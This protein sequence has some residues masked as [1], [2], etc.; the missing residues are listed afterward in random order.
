MNLAH[1]LLLVAATLPGPAQ[2][3]GQWVDGHFLC[4]RDAER[5]RL[6]D[7][8]GRVRL[9][10]PR[11]SAGPGP[12]GQLRLAW[13][14]HAWRGRFYCTVATRRAGSE[15]RR[16][17]LLRFD[18]DWVEL[19]SFEP[20]GPTGPVRLF[21]CG[22]DRVLAVGGLPG[23]G[24]FRML[25][26]RPGG[27]LEVEAELP[28]H[29]AALQEIPEL[30]RLPVMATP[31]LTGSHLS[32]VHRESGW[33]WTFDLAEGRFHRHGRLDPAVDPARAAAPRSLP[34]VDSLQPLPDGGILL[35]LTEGGAPLE[36]N[37]ATA[38]PR[39][40]GLRWVR[41]DPAT[42]VAT[43]FHPEGAPERIR[44]GKPFLWRP[45]PDGS[46]CVEGA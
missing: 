34:V 16:F 46:L 6:L 14:P 20:A 30:L 11:I 27:M 5:G 2:P 4:L 24:P 10:V 32:L 25:R 13:P 9:E 21:P 33:F 12:E 8:A 35:A 44:S 26:P 39:E 45:L 18:G 28:A 43:P 17:S 29:P 36:P 3:T 22:G 19:A 42:G 23:P 7:E 40:L 15:R 1:S 37:A 41:L 38:L 31:V